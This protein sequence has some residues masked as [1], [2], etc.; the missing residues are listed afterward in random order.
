MDVVG[1]QM[2][3]FQAVDVTD[4]H[5]LIERLSGST[6]EQNRFPVFV[7]PGK[8]VD[9]LRLG[10]VLAHFRFI[11]SVKDRGRN[12]ESEGLSGKSQVRFQNLADIHSARHAQ[13]VWQ[14]LDRRSVTQVRQGSLRSAPT[15]LNLM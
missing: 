14:N 4:Y 1:N 9:L 6:V 13:R 3:D 7:D 2:P 15:H 11:D 8:S 5:L 12:L 10:G